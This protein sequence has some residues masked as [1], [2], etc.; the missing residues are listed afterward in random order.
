MP[1]T[2][3]DISRKIRSFLAGLRYAQADFDALFSGRNSLPPLESVVFLAG[4]Q[5]LLVLMQNLLCK[6]WANLPVKKTG[7]L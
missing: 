5:R 7:L 2:A 6:R 4:R 1:F 3:E